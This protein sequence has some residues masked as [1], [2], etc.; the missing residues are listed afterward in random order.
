MHLAR[1]PFWFDPPL[2]IRN[3][4]MSVPSGPGVGLSDGAALLKGAEVLA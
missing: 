2:D 3:G 1:D 4:A